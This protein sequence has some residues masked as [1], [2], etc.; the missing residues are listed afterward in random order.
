MGSWSCM[1]GVFLKLPACK[2]FY[3][4]GETAPEQQVSGPEIESISMPQ[5]SI[6]I[7]MIPPYNDLCQR[8]ARY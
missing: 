8:Q 7:S 4:T 3:L 2:T 5:S 6:M 1:R